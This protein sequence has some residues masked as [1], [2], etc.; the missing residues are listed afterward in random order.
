MSAE[1]LKVDTAIWMLLLRL[2]HFCMCL[3]LHLSCS[4]DMC[5]ESCLKTCSFHL[6]CGAAFFFCGIDG[7]SLCLQCDMDVHIGGKKT[8]ERYILMAQRVEARLTFIP[9]TPLSASWCGE[10]HSM[11]TELSLDLVYCWRRP[12][13]WGCCFLTCWIM[14]I[15]LLVILV[16]LH[17]CWRDIMC[18]GTCGD[19]SSHTL[20]LI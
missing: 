1:K 19:W 5:L 9:L 18:G 13:S 17:S 2:T 16:I 8:H 6:F 7:T 14:Q 3:K 12:Y 15:P 10:S 11:S 20:D 4:P